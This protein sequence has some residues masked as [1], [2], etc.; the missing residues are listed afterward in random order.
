MGEV[1]KLALKVVEV[2]R[3]EPPA[4]EDIEGKATFWFRSAH[5]QSNWRV[6]VSRLAGPPLEKT[7]EAILNSPHLDDPSETGLLRR[8]VKADM[9]KKLEAGL[10]D[11]KPEDLAYQLSFIRKATPPETWKEYKEEAIELLKQARQMTEPT[12]DALAGVLG[13]MQTL[14]RISFDSMP[15]ELQEVFSQLIGEAVQEKEYTNEALQAISDQTRRFLEH[16]I[17]IYRDLES[18]RPYDSLDDVTQAYIRREWEH[19]TY[20]DEFGTSLREMELQICC[21]REDAPSSVYRGWQRAVYQARKSLEVIHDTVQK[22][23]ER[24]ASRTAVEE[25]EKKA[26]DW[27]KTLRTK[28]S[29]ITGTV[30]ERFEPGTVGVTTTEQTG[31]KEAKIW[32]ELNRGIILPEADYFGPNWESKGRE[33]EI[34]SLVWTAQ[35]ALDELT[36]L[37]EVGDAY[38]ATDDPEGLEILNAI[39]ASDALAAGASPPRA[40]LREKLEYYIQTPELDV[41]FYDRAFMSNG[42]VVKDRIGKLAV[43][44]GELNLVSK[45]SNVPLRVGPKTQV[46]TFA[47]RVVETGRGFNR[48]GDVVNYRTRRAMINPWAVQ[49][50]NGAISVRMVHQMFD[51][52]DRYPGARQSPNSPQLTEIVDAFEDVDREL[53]VAVVGFPVDH[54]LG[55]GDLQEGRELKLDEVKK[56]KDQ[57]QWADRDWF[58]HW[59]NELGRQRQVASYPERKLLIQTLHMVQTYLTRR[60]HFPPEKNIT[61][62][63]SAIASEDPANYGTLLKYMQAAGQPLTSMGFNAYPMA[64]TLEKTNEF[65]CFI[66]NDDVDPDTI[67]LSVRF[68][69][70][71]LV[72]E[73]K[74]S[75]TNLIDYFLKAMRNELEMAQRQ[76]WIGGPML[77]TFKGKPVKDDIIRYGAFLK[78]FDAYLKEVLEELDGL[79]DSDP[80]PVVV[81]ENMTKYY[82]DYVHWLTY[83]IFDDNADPVTQ[84]AIPD[85]RFQTEVSEAVNSLGR[86]RNSIV[87]QDREAWLETALNDG[88]TPELKAAA[89]AEYRENARELFTDSTEKEILGLKA[90]GLLP[91]GKE[92]NRKIAEV[93]AYHFI[94]EV[95]DQIVELTRE[96]N[97]KTH[98]GTVD[99]KSGANIILRNLVGAFTVSPGVQYFRRLAYQLHL[100]VQGNIMNNE[101]DDQL[102][103]YF[104]NKKKHMRVLYYI[105]AQVA[106]AI[107]TRANLGEGELKIPLQKLLD[108]LRRAATKEGADTTDRLTNAEWFN[109]MS[110]VEKDQG[111]PYDQLVHRLMYITTLRDPEWIDE[112]GQLRADGAERTVFVDIFEQ[113]L[114]AIEGM[115]EDARWVER[116][117]WRN[118]RH[119]FPSRGNP[120]GQALNRKTTT[121]EPPVI[122][123][124]L[125]I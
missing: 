101:L 122:V 38:L 17:R 66:L 88:A 1:E 75:P 60:K 46:V 39:R 6:M 24:R 40:T 20:N 61:F 27:E 15:E 69:N 5:R 78:A 103:A 115:L 31:H 118:I 108:L 70:E 45:L 4:P 34:K 68:R 114:I 58:A 30:P 73:D 48:T 80:D 112:H 47:P 29:T 19:A 89:R 52:P 76:V 36:Y 10:L 21:E 53:V 93:T 3:E 98:D 11:A 32:N 104:E 62:V 86:Q 82:H 14:G 12:K 119:L 121:N 54:D 7:P 18:T 111:F 92:A 87:K 123:D 43:E 117:R 107:N 67:P 109:A 97:Q 50:Q 95:I 8:Y 125:G 23:K 105:A 42:R 113:L 35:M 96:G 91:K 102:L 81:L 71:E 116:Q 56:Q 120:T 79:P 72:N 77:A 94:T 90:L 22:M 59:I 13:Q 51:R 99:S 124:R 65:G 63:V 64:A 49:N 84:N 9:R 44:G 41:D 33:T 26:R 85:S 55:G 100:P 37:E 25:E 57:S 16:E 110:V 83:N 74:G 28:T 106:E 2:A